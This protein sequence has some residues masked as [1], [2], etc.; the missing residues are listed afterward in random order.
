MRRQPYGY[1][2][3]RRAPPRLDRY[4]IILLG[5][6]GT[7][8]QTTSQGCYLN[9]RGSN[10]RPFSRKSNG[11]NHHTTMP[12]TWLA[13]VKL[14]RL[15][16]SQFWTHVFQCGCS[17]R[18]SRTVRELKFICFAFVCCEQYFDDYFRWW[19]F[20]I[21]LHSPD[22]K[23]LMIERGLKVS[24]GFLTQVAV[25]QKYVSTFDSKFHLTWIWII[26]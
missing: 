3:S 10:P 23:P 19:L 20:Q 6:R 9:G 4:R 26:N 24:P 21:L 12:H 18:S 5:D 7:C 15:V 25:I 14:G 2:P 16:L 1:L 17:Q 8:V 11:L 22:E 13:A